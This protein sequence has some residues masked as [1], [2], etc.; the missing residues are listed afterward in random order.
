M[1]KDH[2]ASGWKELD[3]YH[4][5]MMDTWHPAKGT[6]DLKPLRAKAK[7][8]S[9]TAKSLAKSTPPGACNRAELVEAA[10]LL[11]PASDAVAQQVLSGAS[12]ATLK[13]A[14]HDLHEKFEV[15]EKGCSAHGAKH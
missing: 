7:D 10:R 3:A 12:D 1:D 15:L 5:L 4:K 8:L 11:A 13:S 2:A 6:N 9:A 14:L